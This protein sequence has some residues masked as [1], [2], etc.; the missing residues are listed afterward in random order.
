MFELRFILLRY[1]VCC[2]ASGIA[3]YGLIFFLFL[4]SGHLV[5]VN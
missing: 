1:L 4:F 3:I 5:L 2:F